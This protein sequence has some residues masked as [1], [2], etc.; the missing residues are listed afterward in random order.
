MIDLTEGNQ[1]DDYM[2]TSSMLGKEKRMWN[3]F[4]G[5]GKCII[6]PFDDNLIS[7][8]TTNISYTEK[9]RTVVQS[10][11]DAILTYKGTCGLIC[12]NSISRIVNISAS[13]VN[14]N[15]TNKV[16]VS[17]VKGAL[18]LGAD[19]VAVHINIS[20]RYESEM[21]SQFGR[22]SEICDEYGMPLFALAYPR[23]EHIDESG[24]MTDDNYLSLKN[25]NP[26][27]YTELVC[28]CVKIAFELGADII[29]TQ[30]TG[31]EDSFRKVVAAANGVPVVIAG[32]PYMK[33]DD[34][35][36][37]IY[38]ATRAG[39]SGVSIGRNVFN[40][41]DSN[42]V[43]LAIKKIL[44]DCSSLDETLRFYNERGND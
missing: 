22:V 2:K 43:V 27:E 6:V 18:A 7:G 32:G 39:A 33:I 42:R 1:G 11:P 4:K 23:K 30:Y 3:I 8:I 44:F 10:T 21:L 24:T 20:S 19:A 36:A 41:E 26:D 16:L 15:H 40:R 31:S 14:S 29:K 12:D 5:R 38:D 34:L 35:F 37:T 9:V 13:T 28:K 25:S 17:S